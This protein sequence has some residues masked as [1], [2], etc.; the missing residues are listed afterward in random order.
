MAVISVPPSEYAGLLFAIRFS[1][2]PG[3]GP[4]AGLYNSQ[5]TRIHIHGETGDVT[6][7]EDFSKKRIGTVPDFEFTCT[8]A[9]FDPNNNPFRIASIPIGLPAG[10][11]KLFSFIPAISFYIGGINIPPAGPEAPFVFLNSIVDDLELDQ[12]ANMLSPFSFTGRCA[13]GQATTGWYPL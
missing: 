12:D 5:R 4:S 8:K 3:S 6:S 1:A 10:G 9:S 13:S 7:G 2:P 11:M